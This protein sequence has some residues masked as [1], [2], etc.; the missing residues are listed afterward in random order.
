MLW[1]ILLVIS[2]LLQQY[3]PAVLTRFW[4]VQTNDAC[5]DKAK[6]LFEGEKHV[7]SSRCCTHHSQLPHLE[8]LLYAPSN[9][10]LCPQEKIAR[11]RGEE[12]IDGE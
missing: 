1:R 10:P 4:K 9:Q 6:V 8:L 11:E 5:F 7:D 3:S 12:E 2:L